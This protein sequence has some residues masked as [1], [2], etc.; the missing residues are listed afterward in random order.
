M[1]LCRAR[2]PLL[3]GLACLLHTSPAKAHILQYLSWFRV[4]RI[5]DISADEIRLFYDCRFDPGQFRPDDPLIDLDGDS[6]TSQHERAAFCM[7]AAQYLAQDLLL[8]TSG[9]QVRVAEE[10][11][12]VYED[13]SG[14]RSTFAG[15]MPGLHGEV[16]LFWI[17]PS[18]I[19]LG[20][21]LP[22]DSGTTVSGYARAGGS[23]RFVDAG[24][25]R[26]FRTPLGRDI[27]TVLHLDIK[28]PVDHRTGGEDK[29]AGQ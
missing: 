23:V 4:E 14:F 27:R 5:M 19:P 9:T 25:G 8:F 16:E 3:L 21:P 29:Q 7:Q 26:T 28:A 10:S 11:F 2:L 15:D 17:D 18:F 13:E 24:G 6:T 20:G 1:V 12:Y 22:G